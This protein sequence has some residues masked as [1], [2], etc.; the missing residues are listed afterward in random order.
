MNVLLNIR[1][2]QWIRTG[3]S[4]ESRDQMS[5]STDCYTHVAIYIS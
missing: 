2:S 4:V 3:Q 1:F 5:I